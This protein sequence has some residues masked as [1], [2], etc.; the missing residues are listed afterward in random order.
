LNA[1][2]AQ[3]VDDEKRLR[4]NLGALGSDPEMH[5][6]LLAKFDE[7][8]TAIDTDTAGIAKSSD[9]LTAAQHD[10]TAYIAGLTL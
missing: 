5:K 2:R 10:L 3:L 6:R 1:E 7:T 9:A 8:E 4:D